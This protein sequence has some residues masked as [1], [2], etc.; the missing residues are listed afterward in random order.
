MIE[1]ISIL[2]SM[3][4]AFS[5]GSNDTSNSFGICI[6]CGMITFK[7]AIYL[8]GFFVFLGM[9]QGQ[10]VM[11]TVGEDILSLNTWILLTS[12]I[13][14]A[15][16][17]ILSNMRRFPISSHQVIIGSLVGSGLAFGAVI[18]THTLQKI[19]GS[20]ITSPIIAF[21]LSV[22]IFKIMEN[23]LSKLPV[24]KIERSLRIL[25]LL[26]GIIIAYNT[27]AN[28]L[29]TA[30]GSIV[31]YGLLTPLQAAIA[32]SALVWIGAYLLSPRVVETIYKGIT[33]LEVYS[34]FA[35]QL[36]AGLTVLI[37]TQLGMPV[38]TTYCIIG[39]IYGV[40]I[41]KFST[42]NFKLLRNMLLNWIFT[43]LLAFI[44]CYTT[45]SLIF[46]NIQ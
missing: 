27:G 31:H 41:L 42:I 17:I 16:L 25:V 8:L 3:L 43:P 40:G 37:F 5:I 26:G 29:A 34:G 12:L 24:F 33:T 1:I 2:A 35:V 23:T 15:L 39:G 10:K 9:L 11:K 36:A 14:S 19:L 32:G 20:W 7:R 30:L 45:A 44:I 21:F 28:E 38:S 6:G 4:I 46:L 13:I 18:N 22:L